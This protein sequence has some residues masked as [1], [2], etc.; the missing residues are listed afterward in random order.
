M[1]K[2]VMDLMPNENNP[3][4]HKEA[5]EQL[6]DKEYERQTSSPSR[7]VNVSWINVWWT[8]IAPSSE[9]QAII[10]KVKTQIQDLLAKS[11]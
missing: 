8:R 4:T 6:G 3:I 7:T 11:N 10:N 5:R 2:L 9:L 1:R